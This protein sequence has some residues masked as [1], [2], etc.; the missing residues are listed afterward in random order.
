ME[1]NLTDSILRVCRTLNAS[2]VEYLIVGG[3]A[4]ALHGY[5]R[6]SSNAAGEVVRK[7]D[8]DFWYNPA[9]GNYFKLLDA[10]QDLGQDVTRFKE[11]QTPDPKRS[12]FKYDFE[13]FTLDF[14]PQLKA[15]LP[16]RSAFNRK[17]LI[18]LNETEI[19][20]IG[21]EDLILDKQA[22]ARLKDF[23]DLEHL[24]T[25]RSKAEE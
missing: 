22:N 3:T 25:K 23:T 20:F 4:V 10:L 6:P 9:V 1:D 15:S 17:E 24:K 7:P 14:L 5:F 11:E 8:L 16:F 21:L 18:T 19:P 2:G 13:R 12:F